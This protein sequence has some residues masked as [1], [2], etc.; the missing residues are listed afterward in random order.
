M[1]LRAALAEHLTPI[2]FGVSIFALWEL[3]VRLFHIP[4][5]IIPP[6][7]LILVEYVHHFR[8]I[9]YYTWVTG[10]ETAVGFAVALLLGYRSPSS[11]PSRPFSGAPSIPW[12]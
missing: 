8:R 5:Y 12:R 1:R 2:I 11:S 6:P 4:L 7:S 9:W 10:M 3:A